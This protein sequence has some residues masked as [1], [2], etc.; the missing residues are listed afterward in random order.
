M[1]WAIVSNKLDDR[2]TQSLRW[3]LLL[4][5]LTVML[6]ILAGSALTI[7]QFSRHSLYEQLDRRLAILAQ[8]ASHSLIALRDNYARRQGEN[9]TSRV[10]S[11]KVLCRL[12]EDEDLDIP[13]QSLRTPDQ[14]VEWFDASGQRLGNAGTL[15]PDLP[16]NPGFSSLQPGK[17]RLVT[18]PAYSYQ[19]KQRKLEGYIRTSGS[20]EDVEA[21]LSRLRWG[22][23]V[24]G[25][26]VLGLT[27]LGGVWLV[28]QSL[29]PIEQ[30]LQQLQQFTADASHELRSP[31]TAIKTSIEVMQEYPERIHP[32]DVQKLAAIA[33]ATQQMSHL[34]EDLLLLARIDAAA[35]QPPLI[36]LPLAEILEDLLERLQPQ[37][38][39]KQIALSSHLLTGI[40]VR[41]DGA[42][43]SRLFA[44]LLENALQYTPAGGTVTLKMQ[45]GDRSIAVSVEDTGIGIAPEHLPFLFDRF[46][47]ADC[48]RSRRQGG[49]GLGLAIAQKI[50]VSHRGEIS[51]SSQLGLGSCFRVRLPLYEY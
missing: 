4:S 46:W 11:A 37:A 21:V 1:A 18:I 28:R 36:P 12:D 15:L 40:W 13:W 38:Q 8:A 51:V 16:L 7:Y 2:Q 35:T 33:S 22:L 26:M 23:E 3:R 9:Q 39:A 5:Y 44:N 30:S 47:R 32:Q 17:I 31:L 48:A 14:G 42:Q 10:Q 41:G 45:R 27:G 49:T 19:G 6:A 24:G 50:A 20:T 29:K 34:V 25:I 43:L